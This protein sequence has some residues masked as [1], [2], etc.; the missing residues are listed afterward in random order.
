MQ[1]A[2]PPILG[3]LFMPGPHTQ[4]PLLQVWLTQSGPSLQFSLVGQ[5]GQFRPPQST[6]LSRP[7]K[8]ASVQLTGSQ[9]F[10]TA[11]QCFET[12]SLAAAQAR[13][14]AQA[15]QSAPP[16]STSVSAAFFT[17]SVQ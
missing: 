14:S 7:F 9:I 12:Q 4:R 8:M 2:P 10:V 11:S 5:C 6:S 16:Q 3:T 15:G 13:L 17:P 1:Y